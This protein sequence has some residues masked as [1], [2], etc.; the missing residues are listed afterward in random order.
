M[1]KLILLLI[2]TSLLHSCSSDSSSSSNNNGN[3]NGGNNGNSFTN[4]MDY[5]FTITING[6]VHKV[7]G[8]TTNGIPYGFTSANNQINNKCFAFNG[9]PSN[10]SCNFSINDVTAPNYVSGQNLECQ[11]SFPNLLLGINQATVVFLGGY[12]V[13]LSTSLGGTSNGSPLPFQTVIGTND[14][15]TLFKLPINITDLGST[16]TNSEGGG[17]INYNQYI[18]GQTLKGNYSGTIYIGRFSTTQGIV[19]DIPVQLSIDFRALRRY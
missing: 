4:S 5:E 6:E 12:F 18:F 15:S 1:K 7:K 2:F 14:S 3:N 17:G 19:Y 8:N 11:I 13:T 9:G 16:S 10:V